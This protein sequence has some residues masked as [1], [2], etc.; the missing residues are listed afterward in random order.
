MC[1]CVSS[2]FVSLFYPR[3]NILQRWQPTFS[4][5]HLNSSSFFL[6]L[7][8]TSFPLPEGEGVLPAGHPRPGGMSI[9][10]VCPSLCAVSF[11][12]PSLRRFTPSLTDITRSSLHPC[13]HLRLILPV[14]ALS[15]L[16]RPPVSGQRQCCQGGTESSSASLSPTSTCTR[17]R[18]L[19]LECSFFFL[20]V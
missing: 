8:Y 6:L 18:P 12:L 17:A 20:T 16:P 19:G 15:H 11:S 1:V 13:R 2:I 10:P 3:A 14:C 7:I 5:L 4:S 9:N